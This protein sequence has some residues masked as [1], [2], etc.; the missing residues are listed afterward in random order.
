MAAF[1]YQAMDKGRQVGGVVQADT[2]RMARQQLRERGL[3]PLEVHL[4]ARARPAGRGSTRM[5]RE[6][7]LIL[8]QMAA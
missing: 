2:A 7:A 8:R 5:G 1:E 4:V 6:R 3:V